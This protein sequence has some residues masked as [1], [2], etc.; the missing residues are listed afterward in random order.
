[1]NDITV[2]PLDDHDFD[3]S[4]YNESDIKPIKTQEAQIIDGI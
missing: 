3:L 1:M 2:S 4:F